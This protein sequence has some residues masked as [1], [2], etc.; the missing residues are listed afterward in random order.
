ML[1]ILRASLG[2]PQAAIRILSLDRL[3]SNRPNSVDARGLIVSKGHVLDAIGEDRTVTPHA[4]VPLA[5]GFHQIEVRW[6]PK[7]RAIGRRHAIGMVGQQPGDLG[8]ELCRVQ[9]R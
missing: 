8:R 9:R 2:I 7:L 1:A 4:P 5:E 6:G 3:I